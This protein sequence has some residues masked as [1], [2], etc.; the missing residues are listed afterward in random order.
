MP[1]LPVRADLD[2]L[3]LRA[4]ELLRAAR[5]GDPE[6]TARL[7]AVSDRLV[8]S[9]AQLALVR[10]YGFA[11]WG[12]LRSEVE[13]RAIL[14]QLNAVRLAELLAD[15]PELAVRRMAN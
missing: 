4:K 11:S 12:E 5:F 9:S 3:R 10:E 14:D 13:R 2:Q 6:A 1:H 15:H 7:R 8:L